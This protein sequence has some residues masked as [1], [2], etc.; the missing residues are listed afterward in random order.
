MKKC[1]RNALRKEGYEMEYYDYQEKKGEKPQILLLNTFM[2][3]GSG[4]ENHLLYNSCLTK[5]GIK[6]FLEEKLFLSLFDFDKGKFPFYCQNITNDTMEEVDK[7]VQG[8]WDSPIGIFCIVI[9]TI[10]TKGTPREQTESDSNSDPEEPKKK[11]KKKG[12]EEN[13]TEGNYFDG[14]IYDIKNNGIYKLQ[15]KFDDNITL[16]IAFAC[17]DL[18]QSSLDKMKTRDEFDKL[19]NRFNYNS[20]VKNWGIYI[21]AVFKIYNGEDLRGRCVAISPKHLLTVFHVV[22]DEN[23]HKIIED[24]SLKQNGQIICSF[25]SLK[26]IYP[27]L[28]KSEYFTDICIFEFDANLHMEHAFMYLKS[29]IDGAEK[30]GIP[31]TEG[32]LKKLDQNNI[33]IWKKSLDEILEIWKDKTILEVYNRRNELKMSDSKE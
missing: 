10:F 15:N 19:Y 1:L 12:K 29:L 16:D 22:L 18:D 11:K 27:P 23:T 28:I 21:D 31:F 32:L 3:F 2:M 25:N 24:L 14:S 17:V 6:E 7:K 5:E 4:F 20:T 30:L 8:F 13:K 9:N 26:M 33:E